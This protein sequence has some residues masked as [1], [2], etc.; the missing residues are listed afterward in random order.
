MKQNNSI[1]PEVSSYWPKKMEEL[2]EQIKFEKQYDE[3]IAELN[4]NRKIVRE[5]FDKK[6][7]KIKR[8]RLS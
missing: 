6:D 4:M 5:Y 2:E 1:S 7:S 3:G 8:K